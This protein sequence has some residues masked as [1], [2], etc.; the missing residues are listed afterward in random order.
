MGVWAVS[1]ELK[2]CPFCGSPAELCENKTHDFFV[3]CTDTCCHA[4][5]RNHHENS[6]SAIDSWNERHYDRGLG[7]MVIE[8]DEYGDVHYRIDSNAYL[9]SQE[10]MER[11]NSYVENL[12]ELVRGLDHCMRSTSSSSD[13]CAGCPLQGWSTDGFQCTKSDRMR[14]LGIEVAQ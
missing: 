2:P 1:E 14:D 7:K 10:D 12:R 8:T 3:R 6:V 4:R 9:V 13:E 5:T 11:F